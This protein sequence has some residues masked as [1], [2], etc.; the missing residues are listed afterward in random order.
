M[1]E[2]RVVFHADPA[3]MLIPLAALPR[4]P[5]ALDCSPFLSYSFACGAPPS[6]SL[7]L[8]LPSRFGAR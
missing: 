5:L 6:L 3:A 1:G 8:P 7:N 2:S 4:A